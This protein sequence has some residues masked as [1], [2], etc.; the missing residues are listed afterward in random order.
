[1][2]E[3]KPAKHLRARAVEKL[4]REEER[5][6]IRRAVDRLAANKEKAVEELGSWDEWRE[7][8]KE[9]RKHV[10]ENL[11]F[12][13]RQFTD[14]LR[15]NGGKV[16]FAPEG[17]DAVNIVS[18]I[19]KEH[20]AKLVVKSK[21]MVSEEIRLNDRLLS[22]DVE[23]AETDL[24]EYI[25]QLA[26]EPP[27]HII[28]PSMHKNRRQIA[29]LFSQEAGEKLSSDT[30]TLTAF[31]RRVL[32]EKFLT[33]DIGITGCNF[34]VAETGSVTL[35]TNEGNARMCNTYPKVH[36]AIM[37]MERIVPTFADLEA[38]L[39]LL[40]RSATGQ[41][42]TSYV[43]VLNG[44]GQEADLD[45]PAEMHVIILD[46]GRTRILADQEFRQA[47][48]CTRCGACFNICPVYRQIGGH[49][50]GSVY[51]GPIGAVIT[52]LL[53]NDLD[54]WGEL[55]YAS[56]LCAACSK[57][58]SV[59]IPLHDLLVKLRQKKVAAGFTPLLEKTTFKLWR[60]FFQKSGVYR[61]AIKSAGLAQKPL[62]RSGFIKIGPPPLSAWTN[63]RYFPAVAGKTFR[64]RWKEN[65][66]NR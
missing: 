4:G 19:C 48:H 26:G 35:V 27:S 62:V 17:K 51:G 66:E 22:E 5:N 6:N 7:R 13:L 3:H 64:E 39:T 20:H 63:S 29:E 32:R 55:P 44:P 45:G 49:S 28:V 42:I 16:H 2:N 12:Y 61:F 37:G 56:T 40:P 60:T 23:V 54:F 15:K 9:I 30:P 21:S 14:N 43:S 25:L 41:K 8:G 11:D 10:V 38:L 34:A 52:P 57:V 58:C 53:E 50:Y 46:N 47:L 36:I 33:A 24:A 31:S 18:Q 1:M 59:K 65:D